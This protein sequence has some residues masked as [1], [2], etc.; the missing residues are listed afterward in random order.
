MAFTRVTNAHVPSPQPQHE[1]L[2]HAVWRLQLEV[3]RPKARFKPRK[4]LLLTSTKCPTRSATQRQYPRPLP[5]FTIAKTR[6]RSSHPYKD[7]WRDKKEAFGVGRYTKSFA[8]ENFL[9]KKVFSVFLDVTWVIEW[10]LAS[11]Q[12]NFGLFLITKQNKNRHFV[13]RK[14]TDTG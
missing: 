4:G 9:A 14:T 7:W 11:H 12:V 13:V 3:T 1:C 10:D 2:Q 5:S 6:V 8:K